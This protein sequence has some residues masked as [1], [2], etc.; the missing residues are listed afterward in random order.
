MTK[1]I[2]AWDLVI[3]WGNNEKEVLHNLPQRL[4]VDINNFLDGVEEER[5]KDE[6]TE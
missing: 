6:D 4:I 3:F 5:A 1:K 2:K